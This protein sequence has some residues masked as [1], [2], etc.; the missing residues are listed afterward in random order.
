MA[1]LTRGHLV[2]GETLE[3]VDTC[4]QPNIAT[5][6]PTEAK[7]YVLEFVE[8]IKNNF[9]VRQCFNKTVCHESV[10]LSLKGPS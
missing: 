4:K 5:L 9:Q 6:A 1:D 10:E 7:I 3:A 8:T 2:I